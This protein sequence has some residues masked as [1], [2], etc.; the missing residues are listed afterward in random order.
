MQFINLTP[1]EIRVYDDSGSSVVKRIE[2]SGVVAR[3]V[4]SQTVVDEVDGIKLVKT[5]F[6]GIEG[7][8]EP[9]EGVLYIVSTLTLIALQDIRED[10]IAAPDTGTDSV[11]RDSNGDIIGVKRFQVLRF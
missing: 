9:R 10:V 5:A 7:L 8:P 1:H 2:P 3:V 6:S 11:V 4:P